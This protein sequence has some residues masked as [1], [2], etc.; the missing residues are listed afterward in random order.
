M[1]V[2]NKNVIYETETSPIMYYDNGIEKIKIDPRKDYRQILNIPVNATNNE[3]FNIC[4]TAFL[5]EEK[6]EEWIEAATVLMDLE[7]RRIYDLE[8]A[9]IAIEKEKEKKTKAQIEDANAKQARKEKKAERKQ[10]ARLKRKK[11]RI[12]WITKLKKKRIAQK[13]EKQSKRIYEKVVESYDGYNTATTATN[14]L[15]DYSLKKIA[16]ITIIGTLTG[17]SIVAG[18]INRDIVKEKITIVLDSL[19]DN[20]KVNYNDVLYNIDENLDKELLLADAS[21]KIEK[22]K[23]VKTFTDPFDE[24]QVDAREEALIN[25]FKANNF[26]DYNENDLVNQIKYINCSYKASNDEAWDLQDSILETFKSFTLTIPSNDTY[27]S[28]VYENGDIIGLGLDAFLVDN[29]PNKEIVTE[30]F[31]KFTNLLTAK[32]SQEQVEAANEFLIIEYELMTG[33]K[34]NA[35]GE[36]ISIHDMDSNVGFLICIINR[37]GNEFCLNIIKEDAEISYINNKNEKKL[38]SYKDVKDYFDPYCNNEFDYNNI[39]VTFST[40]LNN[41]AESQKLFYN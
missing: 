37:L 31:E 27:I 25:Y 3:I 21:K 7:A 11:R 19:F 30:L 2:D 17:S 1:K 22:D 24:T 26:Y 4:K 23:Y 39:F 20:D 33:S 5:L 16:I 38:I 29:S 32:T 13:N 41:S 28:G 10:A 35:Y 34:Q 9:K 8:R 36:N 6:K 40:D 18:Y 12:D 14:T 15:K